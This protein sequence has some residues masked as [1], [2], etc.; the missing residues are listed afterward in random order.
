MRKRKGSDTLF[1]NGRVKTKKWKTARDV[2]GFVEE[3]LGFHIDY[4]QRE[5]LYT[6]AGMGTVPTHNDPTDRMI[7]AQ[8]ITEKIPL[9]SSDHKF[10]LYRKYHLNFIYNKR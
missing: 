8:A 3:E 5:H 6:F 7:I 4:I 2:F 10:G 9:I 1:Q